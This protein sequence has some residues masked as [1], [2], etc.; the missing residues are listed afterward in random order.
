MAFRD[1]QELVW[2]KELTFYRDLDR[3]DATVRVDFRGLNTELL[4]GFPLQLD[5]ETARALYDV[6]FAAVER[7]PYFE[8]QSDSPEAEG[9]PVELAK[10]GGTGHY[11]AL[12]W[13]A[14]GDDE[15]GMVLANQGTPAHRLMNG[16]IEVIVLRSPTMIDSGFHPP[17]GAHD[18]GRHE[19]RFALQPYEG[20]VFASGAYRLGQMLNAPPLISEGAAREAGSV[21]QLEAAG[22]VLSCLKPAERGKGIIIRTYEARGEKARG[23]ITL[24]GNAGEACETDLMEQPG[25]AVNLKR[26]TWRPYEV[27]TL[28][29]R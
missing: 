23:S 17:V 12:D 20:E 24:A 3:I 21:L 9:A 27:K 8:V 2:E 10:L 15:W 7:R 22:V 28:L 26:L 13:V 18:N 19:F 16:D 29:V 1:L 25:K 5:L 4:I 11:P 6:P 14:Y